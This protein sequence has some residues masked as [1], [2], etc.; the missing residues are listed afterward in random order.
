MVK[1]T[2]KKIGGPRRTNESFTI[3]SQKVNKA[4]CS[5]FLKSAFCRIQQFLTR[6]NNTS[7]MYVGRYIYVVEANNRRMV[8]NANYDIGNPEF[9]YV[10]DFVNYV[11]DEFKYKQM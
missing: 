5:F 6:E 3:D 1:I 7:K 11:L 8:Y 4:W 2:V 10:K 9:V